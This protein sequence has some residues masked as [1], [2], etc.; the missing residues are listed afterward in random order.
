[1][2]PPTASTTFLLIISLT[3]HTAKSD[4]HVIVRP[5]DSD[6]SVCGGHIPCDTLDS[7]IPYNST[8]FSNGSDLKINFLQGIHKVF[9]RELIQ[10]EGKRNVTWIGKAA[11][12]YCMT[13][14]AFNFVDIEILE[15]RGL[16][17]FKC[18]D[19]L[20]SNYMKQAVLYNISAALFLVL[21]SINAY[22]S[23]IKNA[24]MRVY[25]LL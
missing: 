3:V 12:I 2:M 1:M 20:P 5:T 24:V 9:S 25:Y 7:L 23:T 11:S 6:P 21:S 16:N 14:L 8:L 15:I 19:K 4:T 13:T 18:G 17:F 10:I 22:S